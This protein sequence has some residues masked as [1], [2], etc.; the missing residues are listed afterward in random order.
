M[1]ETAIRPSDVSVRMQRWQLGAWFLDYG[2][3]AK[4]LATR[5]F[6]WIADKDLMSSLVGQQGW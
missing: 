3:S 4:K 5:C 6:L 1:I 2:L